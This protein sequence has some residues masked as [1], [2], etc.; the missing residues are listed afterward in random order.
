[1]RR[2]VLLS[3]TASAVLLD[4]SNQRVSWARTMLDE[5]VRARAASECMRARGGSRPSQET[6]SVRLRSARATAPDPSSRSSHRERGPRSVPRCMC[7]SMRRTGDRRSQTQDGTAQRRG[8]SD[9]ARTCHSG[10]VLMSRDPAVTIAK[11]L[12]E[13][14]LVW[15]KS[16]W[17][18]QGM[19][20]GCT[21]C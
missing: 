3:H 6:Q 14:G 4:I 17:S 8:P 9:E 5:S 11:G 10:G 21:D 7:V 2:V 15:K 16:A 1:M 18:E 13:V 20:E 19:I 12:E